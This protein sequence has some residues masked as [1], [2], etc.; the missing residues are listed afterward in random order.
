MTVAPIHSTIDRIPPNNLEAE[1]ALLGS[2]LVDNEMMAAVS[3]IVRPND[4]Y[5][6]VHE[7]IFL[8]LVELYERGEPVDKITLAEELKRRGMLDHVGGLSYISALMDTVPTAASA[9]ITP[10]SCARKRRCAR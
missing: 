10:R 4:F 2:V 5:A 3:E 6:L 9:G 1:M 7:T 8:A